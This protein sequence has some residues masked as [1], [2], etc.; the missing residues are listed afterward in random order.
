MVEDTFDLERRIL[1]STVRSTFFED[2]FCYYLSWLKMDLFLVNILENL[3]KKLFSIVFYQKMTFKYD[4]H[5]LIKN[6][7]TF[8]LPRFVSV[9]LLTARDSFKWEYWLIVERIYH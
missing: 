4:R 7:N 6:E 1:Q 3:R 8:R 5:F 9:S 2:H